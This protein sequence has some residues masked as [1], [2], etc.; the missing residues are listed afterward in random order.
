MPGYLPRREANFVFWGQHFKDV[1]FANQA[2]LG[3]SPAEFAEI[4][5]AAN[6]CQAAFEA[7]EVAKDVLAGAVFAKRTAFEAAT[8]T[9]R[10][11]GMDF[12]NNPSV[13]ED[14]KGQLGLNVNPSPAGAVTAPIDFAATADTNGTARL[15]WNRNG[16][17]QRT[18]F[19]IEARAA[20]ESTW[21][22]VDSVT[23]SKYTVQDAPVGVQM[24][25]RV[26]AS[27]GG[28]TSGA[29]NSSTIYPNP[30]SMALQL[31]EAA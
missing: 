17:A 14:L 28:V 26:R 11:Y 24:S 6:A 7:V 13:S 19:K 2:A 9:F 15:I 18:V 12:K 8:E 10:T 3:L 20:G 21:T 1:S 30:E 5:D 29:S 4:E 27:R 22:M 31:E 25:Y 23:A 16:N